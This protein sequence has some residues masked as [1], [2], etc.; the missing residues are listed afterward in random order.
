MIFIL[1]NK[2]QVV[3]PIKYIS[4]PKD[5]LR[6]EIENKTIKVAIIEDLKDVANELKE[7]LNEETDIRCSQ[8]Y[9]NA[10]EAISFL[11][12][13]PPNLILI[14]IGLPRY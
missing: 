2:M 11:P 9:Y 4:S 7:L 1:K 5:L 6:V 12:N 3:V 13:N 14:D 10:E 8:V